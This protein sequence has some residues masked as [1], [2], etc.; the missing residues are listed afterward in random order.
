MFRL[1]NHL[2]YTFMF[3]QNGGLDEDKWTANTSSP[4][5][6]GSVIGAAISARLF[7]PP[8]EKRTVDFALAWDSPE[9]KFLKGKSYFR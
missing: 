8:N 1:L 6:Q 7:I 2:Y 4:S 9:V 3:L 5:R